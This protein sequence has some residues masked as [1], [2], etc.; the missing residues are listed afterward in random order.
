MELLFNVYMLLNLTVK[1]SAFNYTLDPNPTPDPKL[2]Q[3]AYLYNEYN[4]LKFK[5][6][7]PSLQKDRRTHTY[8]LPGAFVVPS[9]GTSR[10]QLL[11]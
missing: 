2:I 3:N 5:F 1:E 9:L 6:D 11:Q 10:E 7:Y 8:F 4:S